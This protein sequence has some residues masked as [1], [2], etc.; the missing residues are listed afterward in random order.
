MMAIFFS[1]SHEQT[2]SDV[3]CELARFSEMAVRQVIPLQSLPK[4]VE[5]GQMFEVVMGD[6]KNPHSFN[7]QLRQ[8][9]GALSNMMDQLDSA[10]EEKF[11]EESTDENLPHPEVQPG[12]IYL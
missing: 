8:N 1:Q 4:E 9:F 5:N 11:Q 7:L 6:V 12:G 2:L 10:M 3:E